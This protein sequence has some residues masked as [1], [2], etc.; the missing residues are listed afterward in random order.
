MIPQV[1]RRRPLPLPE[2]CNVEKRSRA[3]FK[4]LSWI[5]LF[6]D[7]LVQPS[8][9]WAPNDGCGWPRRQPWDCYCKWL[10]RLSTGLMESDPIVSQ[11]YAWL[12][13]SYAL[14]LKIFSGNQYSRASGQT[15]ISRDCVTE[16]STWLPLLECC[17]CEASTG[18]P[19]YGVNET[20]RG[21]ITC[22]HLVDC[23]LLFPKHQFF[24]TSSCRVIS[25]I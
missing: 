16:F 9:V 13:L 10:T 4:S 19:S 24:D 17:E 23:K 15:T 20:L 22:H 1:F 12:L 2:D 6:N 7:I 3:N 18:S 21:V 25:S 11:M 14:A 8:V 5:S